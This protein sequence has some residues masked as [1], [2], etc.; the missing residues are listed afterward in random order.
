[1][2][3]A[4]VGGHALVMGVGVKLR[5]RRQHRRQCH[6]GSAMLA[7]LSSNT[8][9]QFGSAV[10]ACNTILHKTSS[11]G[12]KNAGKI[13]S[14]RGCRFLGVGSWASLESS[15]SSEA[16][17]LSDTLQ[18]PNDQIRWGPPI[19]WNT[20]SFQIIGIVRVVGIFIRRCSESKL[21]A[22]GS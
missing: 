4:C 7:Y 11:V 3:S 2:K 5:C 15:E 16:L 6:V 9:R 20:S 1:M 10:G 8:H 17:E 19:H 14:D 18:W 21:I 13:Q 12:S 22:V